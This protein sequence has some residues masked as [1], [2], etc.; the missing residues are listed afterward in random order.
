[1]V[2]KKTAKSFVGSNVDKTEPIVFDLAGEEIQALPHVDGWTTIS[3]VKNIS[4]DNP[5]E[6]MEAVEEYMENSFDAE[7]LKK[8]VKIVKDPTKGFSVDDITNIM[9]YLFEERSGGKDLA[10]SSES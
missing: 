2:A 6:N 5:G 9:T 3:F 8:F 1:M 4:G 10:E 7:N